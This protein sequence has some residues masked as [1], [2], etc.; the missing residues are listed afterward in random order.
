[1]SDFKPYKIHCPTCGAGLVVRSP[2][3]IG[4]ILACPKCESMVMIE[5]LPAEV[6]AVSPAPSETSASP[7]L[8][9]QRPRKPASEPQTPPIPPVLAEP[10]TENNPAEGNVTGSEQAH[11]MMR[12][13]DR[14][15][16]EERTRRILL[17]G[18]GALAG[19][20]LVVFVLL[21]IFGGG[22]ADSGLAANG[23]GQEQQIDPP[24]GNGRPGEELFV[25]ERL[26][27]HGNKIEEIFDIGDDP[28]SIFSDIFPEHAP[29]GLDPGHEN[30]VDIDEPVGLDDPEEPARLPDFLPEPDP[31]NDAAATVTEEEIP[32]PR[33]IV[34]LSEEEVQARLEIGILEVKFEKTPFI[35][36]IETLSNLSNVPITLDTA[37]LRYRGYSCEIPI[38]MALQ[39]TNVGKALDKMLEVARLIKIVRHGQIFL[40]LPAAENSG[41]YETV[42]DI[43]DIARIEGAGVRIPELL[44]RMIVPETWKSQGGDASISIE[45][46]KLRIVHSKLVADE[47]L[48][49]LEQWRVLH[50][51]PQQTDRTEG[52]LAPEV[53][54]WDSLN[55][56]I[57]LNY[58]VPTPL[59]QCF[60]NIRSRTN[61]RILTNHLALIEQDERVDSTY[62]RVYASKEKGDTIDD[63]LNGFLADVDLCYR[64]I[65]EKT[66]EVT[67]LEEAANSA[68]MHFEVHLLSKQGKEIDPIEA[69]GIIASIRGAIAPESWR[70][71]GNA[72]TLGLGDLAYDPESG[73]LI[74]RQS[75]PV[76]RMIR[77]WISGRTPAPI[78]DAGPDEKEDEELGVGD[79]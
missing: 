46:D 66:I 32:A 31:A 59:S 74:V 15:K 41:L 78:I 1:M 61:L 64:I 77:K 23:N 43:S 18:L 10:D 28:N 16:H 49:F 50:G 30:S 2:K 11:P 26:D 42:L 73:C 48:R 67:T 13:S 3:L 47:V 34:S 70:I 4:Q 8:P 65:D 57:T 58:Y 17:V 36:A 53:F 12:L 44:E 51:I 14:F 9:P 63:A 25:E 33:V 24:N 38:T 6:P 52:K 76:Q 75:Q 72:R 20:L 54:G 29:E 79:E 22:D 21:Q 35:D 7:D 69:E 37:A 45:G 19:L 39:D 62:S 68:N 60:R 27:D 5:P 55:V 56:P 40:T 71:P